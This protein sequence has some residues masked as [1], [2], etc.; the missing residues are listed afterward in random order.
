MRP[1]AWRRVTRIAIGVREASIL[2]L[3]RT[4]R[5]FRFSLDAMWAETARL[6]LLEPAPALEMPVFSFLGRKDHWVPPEVS[7]ADFE[8]LPAPSKK[9]LWFEQSG[10][11]SFADEPAKFN[12][13]MAELV[14]PLLP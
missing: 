5:A 9:I 1:G 10:H 6:N 11:E 3:P 8:A 13:A 4:W 14:R 12:T 2:D 7:L